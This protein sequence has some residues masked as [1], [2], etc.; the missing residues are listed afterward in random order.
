MAR[1]LRLPALRVEEG[2]SPDTVRLLEGLLRLLFP[3][4]HPLDV[5]TIDDVV[6][7]YPLTGLGAPARGRQRDGSGRKGRGHNRTGPP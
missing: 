5:I 6:R 1:R 4:P 3:E 7:R 2:L